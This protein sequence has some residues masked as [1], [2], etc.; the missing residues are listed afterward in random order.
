MEKAIGYCDGVRLSL[1]EC[2]SFFES[3]RR[4]NQNARALVLFSSFRRLPVGTAVF[5][6]VVTIRA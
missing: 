3:S 1:S 2:E 5:F 6:L 4:H